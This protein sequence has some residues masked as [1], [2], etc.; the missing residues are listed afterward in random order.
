MFKI[1]KNFNWIIISSFT[2]IFLGIITFLT[3]INEGFV[4][5]N[6]KNLLILLF[7]DIIL[8][9]IFFYLIFKNFIRFY[10]AGQKNKSGSQT[11]FKYV[12][13]FSLFTFIPSLLIAVFSLF[14]F[15]FGLERYFDDQITKAVNNSNDVAKNYLEESKKMLNRT[16][17]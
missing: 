1:I 17:F 11:N 14:I 9:L 5:L 4:P 7:V 12:S 10:T 15:N 8:L 6:E 13:L 3:F 16:L 2:C